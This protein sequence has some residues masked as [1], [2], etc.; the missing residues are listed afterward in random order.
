[1]QEK[2]WSALGTVAVALLGAVGW[3]HRKISSHG[4]RIAKVETHS[5][6]TDEENDRR[7]S[8]VS[9]RL[10]RIEDKLDRVLEGRA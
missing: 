9:V 6:D 3:V 7:F 1:M 2:M 10:G 8:D 5:A 4:V